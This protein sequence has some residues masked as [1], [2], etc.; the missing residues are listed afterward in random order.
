M[1]SDEVVVAMVVVVLPIVVSLLSFGGAIALLSKR[2]QKLHG[3]LRAFLVIVA[4]LIGL[5]ALAVGSCYGYFMCH[6][7]NFH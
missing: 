2:G 6:P 5:T 4:L 7:L 1:Q 3:A